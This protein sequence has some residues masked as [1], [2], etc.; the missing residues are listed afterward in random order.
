MSPTTMQS[1]CTVTTAE[2]LPE[3]LVAIF[4]LRKHHPD[5]PIYVACQEA[6]AEA[7]RKT[8]AVPLVQDLGDLPSKV[9]L[10]NLYHRP[11]AI[12]LKMDAMEHAIEKH[13]DAL[14]FDADIV[15]MQPIQLPPNVGEV[16]LSLNL[17]VTPNMQ[18]NVAKFGLFN[19]GLLWSRSLEFVRWWRQEYLNPTMRDAFYEQGCLGMVPHKWQTDYFPLQHN[20]GFWRG[21]PA[22]GVASY[23]LHLGDNLYMT[24]YIRQ[25][26]LA[27]RPEVWS[28]LPDDVAAYAHKQ[29]GHPEKVWFIHYGKA[30]GVYTSTAFNRILTGYTKKDSWREPF[31]L[32]RDWTAEELEHHLTSSEPFTFLHQHHVSTTAEQVILARKNGWKTVMFYRDPRE[33]ICSLYHFG[34][35][36]I[37]ESGEVHFFD[38]PDTDLGTFDQFFTRVI[39]YPQLW[40]LPDW[41]DL[42]DYCLPFSLENLDKVMI[43]M[44]GSPHLAGPK[45]NTSAN[46]GWKEQMTSEHLEALSEIP[47]FHTSLDFMNP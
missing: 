30:A 23:H 4:S 39:K 3:C 12:R 9:K 5:L 27:L 33:L 45:L 47:A 35:R 24:D 14:F 22:R 44:T 34:K 32:H 40:S 19:A 29:L 11:D 20:W 15:F 6:Q 2:T 38:E 37:A 31:K 10:H 28:H 21:K 7:I 13:G 36:R 26:T 16:M 18:E 41:H 8:G 25:G 1:A 17:S 43:E 46:P 42:L